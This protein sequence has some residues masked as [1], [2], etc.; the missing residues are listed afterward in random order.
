MVTLPTRDGEPAPW[1][2]RSETRPPDRPRWWQ[3]S[4]PPLYQ[5]EGLQ[6]VADSSVIVVL[7]LALA[8]IAALAICLQF[9]ALRA[10]PASGEQ[11]VTAIALERVDEVRHVDGRDE[12]WLWDDGD[13]LKQTS[14]ASLSDALNALG[15]GLLTAN[16]IGDQLRGLPGDVSV[17]TVPERQLVHHGTLGLVFLLMPGLIYMLLLAGPPPWLANRWAWFWVAGCLHD[18][19]ALAVLA[20]ALLS[21]PL[22]G[23][24]RPLWQR[25][26]R[27][28]EGLL[29]LVGIVVASRYAGQAVDALG[30]LLV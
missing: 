11:L 14:R 15:T 20:F 22:P 17:L 16:E 29:V 6:R 4:T 24:R 5:P 19:H 7:R 12:R 1:D 2:E 13:G 8:V 30:R 3:W 26:L 23:V 9:A 28:P 27:G 25:R 10:E 21:G 18:A